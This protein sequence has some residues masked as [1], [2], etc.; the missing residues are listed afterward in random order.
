MHYILL[1]NPLSRNEKTKNIAYK[2]EKKLQKKGHTTFIGSILDIVDVG[3]YISSLKDDDNIVILGGDGTIHHLVNNVRGYDIKQNVY[4]IKKAGT[5]NDFVRSLRGNG[6]FVLINDYIKDVPRVRHN[7][8]EEYKVF[9]NSV[10][11]G[12]DAHV[13]ELVN[14]SRKGKS[15]SNYFKSAFKA[16]TT[17]KPFN[18][19]ITIDGKREEHEKVW[20]VLVTNSTHF[21]GG[22]KVSPKSK[23]LDDILEVI[24]I[25]R[26]PRFLLFLIFPTIYIGLHR[27]FKR[28]VKFYEG[29]H[30]VLETKEGQYVQHDGEAYYPVSYIE[31][32]R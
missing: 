16:F 9:A 1:Y 12:I 23:R 24:V 28:W 26:V 11:M 5:G 13:C 27:L 18:V 21:G 14:R 4:T 2:L 29:K 30:I 20:F 15:D 10:G 25:K 32:E 17:S 22:M 8:E 31:V 19:A 6:M 7:K 3:E